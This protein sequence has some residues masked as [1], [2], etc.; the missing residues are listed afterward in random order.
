MSRVSGLHPSRLPSREIETWA[1]GGK[2]SSQARWASV[3]SGIRVC[4]ATPH[5]AST[6]IRATSP[7]VG[8]VLPI[9]E[10]SPLSTKDSQPHHPHIH[11]AAKSLQLCLTLCDPTEG[12]PLGSSVP[13]IL[14]ARILEWVAISFSHACMRAKLLQSYPTLCDAV[15]SSPRGSTVHRILPARILEWAAVS[16]QF[17]RSVVSDSLRPYESQHARPP[18]PS[19]TPGVHPD[20]RPSSQ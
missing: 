11:L 6:S 10:A 3:D 5:T 12:S 7:P 19:P 13:G 18:C 1:S 15:D 2:P 14:Q 17:S 20:S 16:V 4:L 8:V 9:S